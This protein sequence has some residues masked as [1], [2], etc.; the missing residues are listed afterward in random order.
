MHPD[1]VNPDSLS[2]AF[3]VWAAVVGMV[4]AALVWELARLRAELRAMSISLSTHI[5]QT[6]HRLTMAEA[7]IRNLMYGRYQEVDPR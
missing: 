1:G 7:N 6:E 2:Q 3:A 5:V 4:G